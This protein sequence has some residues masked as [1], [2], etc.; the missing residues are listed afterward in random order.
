MYLITSICTIT[1]DLTMYLSTSTWTGDLTMYM[2]LS[3]STWTGDLTMYMYLSTITSTSTRTGDLMY[4]S[5]SNHFYTIYTLHY[6]HFSLCH[7]NYF[8]AL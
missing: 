5:T 1:G 7:I 6:I 8:R 4:L 3:T 2:Y